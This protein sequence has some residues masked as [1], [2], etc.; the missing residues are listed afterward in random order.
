MANLQPLRRQQSSR[1]KRVRH[2]RHIMRQELCVAWKTLT[3]MP[4]DCPACNVRTD[5]NVRVLRHIGEP[6]YGQPMPENVDC[7]CRLDQQAV[8]TVDETRAQQTT[9]YGTYVRRPKN[10]VPEVLLT[11]L[12]FS[13]LQLQASR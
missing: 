5:R 3:V 2:T 6:F 4:Q 8:E 13:I 1:V 12:S 10:H 11:K 9:A 7:L